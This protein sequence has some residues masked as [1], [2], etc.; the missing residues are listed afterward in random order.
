MQISDFIWNAGALH[1]SRFDSRC[2]NC[3]RERRIQ[4]NIG[5][6]A[7]WKFGSRRILL[8]QRCVSLYDV[9]SEMHPG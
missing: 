8:F 5:Y 1:T 2:K 4:I 9:P 6:F 7:S 3:Q